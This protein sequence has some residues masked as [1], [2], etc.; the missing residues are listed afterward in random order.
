MNAI[1]KAVSLRETPRTPNTIKYNKINYKNT[2]IAKFP[3]KEDSLMIIHSFP[4]PGN[5][6]ME[7]ESLSLRKAINSLHQGK[8]NQY[9]YD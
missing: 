4:H 3:F 5:D 2:K 6:K 9:S 7:S 8:T 1:T